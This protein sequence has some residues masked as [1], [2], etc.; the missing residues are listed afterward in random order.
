MDRKERIIRDRAAMAR[1]ALTRAG[2]LEGNEDKEAMKRVDYEELA[3]GFLADLLHLAS[4]NGQQPKAREYT[5][6]VAFEAW[7]AFQA[8]GG[9]HFFGA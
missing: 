3:A 8:D 5:A 2:Y 1:K 6:R 4:S 7:N 9:P